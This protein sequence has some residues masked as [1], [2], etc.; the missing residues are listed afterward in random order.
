[1]KD[2]TPASLFGPVP[3]FRPPSVRDSPTSRAA[4]EA[5]APRATSYREQVFRAIQAA[6]ENGLTDEEGVNV[7]GIGSST[8]R[9]RRY[10]LADAG[11]IR[12]SKR[13]RRTNSGCW[14]VVWVAVPTIK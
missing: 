6:G 9:P 14:A 5:V 8:W 4:A 7:T 12:D 2:T 1:M 13:T 11:R 10:E 3:D